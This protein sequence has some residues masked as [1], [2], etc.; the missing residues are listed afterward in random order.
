MKR[1]FRKIHLWLSVPFGVFITLICFSGAMLVFEKEITELC[2]HD[3]YFVKEVGDKPLPMD[4]LMETV[5]ATLPDSV[6][7]TGV[8]VSPEPERAYQLSLSKPRR[9]SLYVDQYT[10]EVKGK[11]ERLPFYDTM[12]HLHRWL[13]GDAQAKD[14]GMSVGKL[15]VGISTLVLVIILITGLLMW[16]TNRKK[17]LLKS[18]TISFTKGWPRFWHD[19]HVAGGIYA[20]VF[21]LAL[22]LTGL[23]WSFSWYRTGFYSMFGVEA[24]AGGGHGA[25]GQKGR[26]DGGRHGREHGGKEGRNGKHDRHDGSRKHGYGHGNSDAA[27]F[28]KPVGKRHDGENRR[29]REAVKGT[30]AKPAT[31]ENT[32]KEHTDVAGTA[33]AE[34]PERR[35]NDEYGGDHRGHRYHEGAEGRSHR[36]GRDSTMRAERRHKADSVVRRDDLAD[37]TVDVETDKTPASDAVAKA[38][39]GRRHGGKGRHERELSHGERGSGKGMKK[40]GMRRD[41]T[42]VAQGVSVKEEPNEQSVFACWQMVYDRLAKSNP[43]FRQITISDGSASVVPEGRASLRAGD[44]FDFDMQTG[45]ITEGKPYS[46]QDKSV[47]VRG[48][49][50]MLHVGSWGGMITRIL[51]FL[52]ALLGATLPLT[53]YYLWIRRLLVKRKNKV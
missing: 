24:S 25:G 39:N 51:T 18:L 46:E 5:S 31:A 35:G 2:R 41:S 26:P 36:H 29:K 50:Y 19:L 13:L 10:G 48:G 12:F 32:V 43:G 8:T 42:S 27:S 44:T 45:R 20:T 4:K 38:S 40:H 52:A 28:E 14:G 37:A 15:L 30:Q 21:L 3:L 22:A 1:V 33:V 53:G 11:N 7:I 9:A 17:P 47:K 34:R 6:T 16:L 23:T 49:V